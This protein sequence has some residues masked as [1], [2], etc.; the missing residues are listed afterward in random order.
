[1]KIDN[2]KFIK[3]LVESDEIL[4]D[5]RK[6]IAFIGRSNVGKSSIINALTNNKKLAITSSTPGRTQQINVFLINNDFYLI[7]LP[8]YGYAKSSKSGRKRIQELINWY[9]FESKTEIKFVVLLID[10]NIGPTND[11]LDMLQN[12]V[13]TKKNIIIVANKIDKIKKSLVQKQINH[14]RDIVGPHTIIPFSA[15]KKQG[16]DELISILLA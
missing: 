5:G 9:L 12:L 2:A 10:A 4:F 7:D 1:M 14:I 13:E 6:Q 15:E 3:G 11:D 16:I 8:G